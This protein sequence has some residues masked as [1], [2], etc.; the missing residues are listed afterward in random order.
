MTPS[1]FIEKWNH[2]GEDLD[3]S[4]GYQCVDGWKIFTKEV[5]G[6]Y[7]ATPNGW[8]DGYWYN[9]AEYTKYF[10]PIPNGQFK[11]GD[12]VMWAKGSK[13]HPS[14]HIAMYFQGFEF[15]MNQGG[16]RTFCL[17]RTDFSD[18]LGALRWEGYIMPTDTEATIIKRIPYSNRR[19]VGTVDGNR[20]GQLYDK[21]ILAGFSDKALI[22]EGGKEV[23][24]V[25]GSIFYTWDGA[26]YAEGL[27]KSR[28]INNQSADMSCVYK[29]AEVMA[30]GF[31]KD[32][33]VTFA[34]Q[35]DIQRDLSSYYG[36]ITGAFGI[37][38]DGEPAFWGSELDDQRA[39]TFTVK[40]G[41]TIIGRSTVTKEIIIISTPGITGQSGYTGEELYQVCLDAGCTDAICLDGGGSRKLRYNGEVLVDLGR[42][43]KNAVLFYDMG[44]KNET[45]Q[46]DSQADALS[47]AQIRNA[48]LLKENTDLKIEIAR[49]NGLI[50]KIREII[51]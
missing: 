1:E 10:E 12:W 49:L 31:R 9:R 25:N 23:A 5:I 32:G 11:D 4:F 16:D 51:K 47:E 50:N 22:A 42:A 26:T 20:F 17:K 37:M 39:H 38:K 15:G 21:T 27:E 35:K 7:W 46:G 44:A 48:E 34:K 24:C 2:R 14:S 29:F 33:T 40:S 13:S 41:R 6:K 28:G 3:K 18:A 19:I 36:A 45:V 43:V 8:A 30:I